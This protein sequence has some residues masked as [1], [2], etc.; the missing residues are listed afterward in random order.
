MDMRA[1]D[2][3]IV[4]QRH[5]RQEPQAQGGCNLFVT[6]PNVMDGSNQLINLYL[7]SRCENGLAG[8]PCDAKLKELRRP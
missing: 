1:M 8:W 2:W 4:T 7:A 6:V 3:A 5:N